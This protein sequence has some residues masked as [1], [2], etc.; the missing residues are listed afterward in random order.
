MILA[1]ASKY[2][3]TMFNGSFRESTDREVRIQ[4][5]SESLNMII[6]YIYTASIELSTDSVVEI[7]E[8]A[9]LFELQT[10]ADKYNLINLYEKSEN[11]ICDNFE[12]IYKEENE[13]FLNLDCDILNKLISSNKL[14][15]ESEEQVFNCIKSWVDHDR[16]NRTICY[17]TLLQNVRLPLINP[18][19]ITNV[20]QKV[21]E[22]TE[23][24]M[25]INKT[26]Q[27]HLLPQLR[28]VLFSEKLIQPRYP[29]HT[30]LAIS[31]W[32]SEDN[33]DVLQVGEFSFKLNRWSYT[34]W[35]APPKRI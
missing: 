30:L 29:K 24:K 35:P 26:L 22:S 32:A 16:D 33:L 10:I 18:V 31:G 15:V 28:P 11:Y 19:F 9:H 17:D 3:Q 21:C 34:T 23:C 13:E 4:I 5:D 14:Q 20:I 12:V 2:F 7:L 27:W 6:K 8:N 1:A 25:L